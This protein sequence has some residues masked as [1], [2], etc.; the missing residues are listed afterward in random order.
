MLALVA[1][2]DAGSHL[3][4]LAGPV[5]EVSLPPEREHYVG[6]GGE[7]DFVAARE[8]WLDEV[9]A[10]DAAAG[11][12]QPEDDEESVVAGVEA[13]DY[14]PSPRRAGFVRARA[15]QWDGW[16][17]HAFACVDA[18]LGFSGS[19]GAMEYKS[20]DAAGLGVPALV[21]QDRVNR[22]N[23]TAR[24]SRGTNRQNLAAG[25]NEWGASLLSSVKAGAALPPP[26]PSCAGRP[27]SL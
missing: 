13:P 18:A 14:P 26:P 22:V 23:L 11:Y 20:L 16:R 25:G 3:S 15:A 1:G 21:S 17:A 24:R 4:G 27:F 2:A 5:A 8:A 19:E 7:A 10:I 12:V 9:D 6:L